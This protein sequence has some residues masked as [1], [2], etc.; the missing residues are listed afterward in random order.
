MMS[1]VPRRPPLLSFV[2][3]SLVAFAAAAAVGGCQSSPP[4]PSSGLPTVKMQIGSKMFTLEVADDEETRE[5]GLMRRDSMPPDHGM[6]FVFD[7]EQVLPFYMKN[8]RIPLDIIFVDKDGVVVAVKQMKPYDLSITSSDKPALWAIEL[9][10]GAAAAAGVKAGDL[11]TVPP[12]ARN[13]KP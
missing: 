5:R 12:A 3:F 9:N 1:F 13:P 10:Q 8:T 11:V 2:L 6:I 4:Q 7:R